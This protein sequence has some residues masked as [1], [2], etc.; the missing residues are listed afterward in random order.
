MK[1]HWKGIALCLC[2]LVSIVIGIKGC[3][4]E[5]PEQVIE[6][7]QELVQSDVEKQEDE[8]QS[9]EP[10]VE[11]KEDD[12]S[13][14]NQK[15]GEVK[16]NKG[17][18]SSK[19]QKGTTENKN[20]GNSVKNPNPVEIQD[21]HKDE[22]KKLYCTLSISCETILNNMNILEPNKESYVPKN[23][24][25]YKEKKVVFYEGESVFDVLLRETKSNGIQMEFRMTPIY[26]SNYIEGIN[27][28]YEFDCGSLSGWMYNVNGWYPNYGCSRYQL[29]D[30]DKIQWKY[31]C[32]LGRDLGQNWLEN[33]Q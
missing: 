21:Q 22:K 3:K 8:E 6:N 16:E 31:T 19:E 33:P 2:I 28:L 5:K 12:T 11:S 23:G 24:I 9:S 10:K 27:N 29:K 13:S 1:K 4:I 30:G 26:S 25:I 32:D 15:N 20:T 18:S 14:V 17:S 7:S